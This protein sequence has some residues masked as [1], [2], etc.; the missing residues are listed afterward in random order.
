MNQKDP[1]EMRLL[2]KQ[3][4]DLI[5]DPDTPASV[6]LYAQKLG[7]GVQA[8]RYRLRRFDLN[9]R[10][11]EKAR[12]PIVNAPVKPETQACLDVLKG[13]DTAQYTSDELYELA[14]Y[15]IK[16]T[17]FQAFLRMNRIPFKP[18]PYKGSK[19]MR[20]GKANPAIT[21]F[22]AQLRQIAQR[23]GTNPFSEALISESNLSSQHLLQLAICSWFPRT[24]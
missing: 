18:S 4:E 8:V 16:L 1:N 2:K 13:I 19:R 21:G 15:P 3:L 23:P 5:A 14:H 22:I 9:R 10:Y 11:L 17:S 24:H 6:D 20:A 7:L 12:H